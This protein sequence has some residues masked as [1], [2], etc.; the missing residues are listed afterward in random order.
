MKKFSILS[1]M[2]ALLIAAVPVAAASSIV[3][4][5][6]FEEA[7]KYQLDIDEKIKIN[8]EHLQ[9]ITTLDAA[10]WGVREIEGIQYANNLES[11]YLE[12]NQIDNIF[13]L[14]ELKKV[15]ILNLH[16]NLITDISPISTYRDLT[17][18]DLSKNKL[19]N[20]HALKSIS[21]AKEGG[22][23]LSEN[24]I[25][26][27]SPLGNI[28]V[29]LNMESFYL[30][31]ENN[32][33]TSLN[34]LEKLAG[35]TE[36][37]AGNN[38]LTDISSIQDLQRLKYIDLEN[39]QL[40][41]ITM[42]PDS[43]QLEV[44]KLA[45]NQLQSMDELK[46]NTE[47][48]LYIDVSNNEISDITSL[49]F[50]K[51]GIINL[52]NNHISD[53]SSLENM[54]HG[55]VN[56]KGN[57]ISPSSLKTIKLLIEKGITIEHDLI[58]EEVKEDEKRIAGSDRYRTAAA[59]AKQGW[60][61][62]K[63]VIIASGQSFPD[64]LSGVPLAF[65][66]DAPILLVMQNELASATK[67]M[68]ESLQTEEVI[69]LGGP[70][71]VSPNV[72]HQ[73]QKMNISV[74]RIEGKDRFDT[75]AKIA[76]KLTG[77]PDTAI[78]AYGYDFP[79]ALSAAS[80][81]AQNGYP[82]LLTDRDHLPGST[83]LV[84][85]K[86]NRALIIGGEKVVSDKV[87]NEI[88]TNAKERINGKN[89][90]HTSA[91]LM[92]HS[93]NNP[94]NV[95]IGNGYT[96][97]DSL[98]GS[99][100]AAKHNAPLLLVDKHNIPYEIGM[101]FSKYH[102]SDFR[103]LGGEAVL[104]NEM[105]SKLNNQLAKEKVVPFMG[106]IQTFDEELVSTD[107]PVAIFYSPHQDDEL[108]TMGHAIAYYVDNGYDVHVVL[109]TDGANSQSIRAVNRQF[110][111]MNL[112]PLTTK[113]FSYARSLEFVRSLKSLGVS[114]ENIHFAN[115]EDGRTTVS[116]ISDVILK[117]AKRYPNAEHMAFSFKDD[118]RDHQNSG[119]ALLD[120]Y[121]AGFIHAA[122]F[123]IQNNERHLWQGDYEPNIEQYRPAIIDA[124]QYYR[125]WD[126]LRRMYSIGLISVPYD[127]SLLDMDPRSKYH[128]P[129]YK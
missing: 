11:I 29:P 65:Q 129:D 115:Y 31:V 57:P 95:F 69:I 5:P 59:I 104:S 4:Q 127:F 75:A 85:E 23:N 82:I 119:L 112:A 93:G 33:I 38:Q 121:S 70:K 86:M 78:V 34:G 14:S 41:T 101:L 102:I 20:L 30:N 60:E 62:A 27:L 99:V 58:K 89:R 18:L 22:I 16:N 105:L 114:R 73:L 32:R 72:E 36:L 125:E 118:H 53:I 2:I 45:N 98:T 81:A 54:E 42:L 77:N 91:L 21:F 1:T 79:D 26:D 17:V 51:R 35:L 87:Y 47:A 15:K 52:A 66:Y 88:N 56:V 74:G 13:P 97:A 48:E 111:Q 110:Q 44:L 84:L 107:K 49:Q 116:Q 7:I 10:W 67:A 90:F 120:L 94:E 108:L 71:A 19:S 83:K 124:A 46:M 9:D 8:K 50:V 3:K 76:E 25:E 117:Y 12:G 63:K 123:Y 100:L 28:Y 128:G 43:G 68:L 92:E 61:R 122:K 96:F 126:P 40:S 80:F 6:N 39:N 55:K 64:A 103:L 109:L 106:K 24:E 37:Y 113:E